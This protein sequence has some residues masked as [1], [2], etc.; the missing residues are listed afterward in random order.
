MAITLLSDSGRQA[1]TIGASGLGVASIPGIVVTAIATSSGR[2]RLISWSVSQDGGSIERLRDSGNQGDL[3]DLVDVCQAAFGFFVTASRLP[4][5]K[6]RVI[7]WKV[8]PQT[9]EIDRAEDDGD[10]E[11]AVGEIAMAD[12]PTSNGSVPFAVTDG[13]GNL[14]LKNWEVDKFGKLHRRGD[15]A[16]QGAA[17]GKASQLALRWGPA[18]L[19]SAMRTA[20]GNLKLIVWS[21]Q[22][23]GSFKRLGQG[24]AGAVSRVSLTAL[25]D[26]RVVTAVRDAGNNLKLISWT[27]SADGM[28]LKRG[29]D[30]G[31]AAGG[32][33][34]IASVF[35]DL[36]GPTPGSPL[37]EGDPILLTAVR[38]KR[39][40]LKLIRWTVPTDTIE[41]LD[42]FA[43]NTGPVD[44]IAQR[45]VS[46]V[47][48]IDIRLV[49][50][51]DG[52]GRLR[53]M[54][55]H[56]D[57]TR[58]PVPLADAFA[59]Y[60]QSFFENTV[61][62]VPPS[63]PGGFGGPACV[64]G[65]I[66]VHLG[67][68]RDT[69]GL[70]FRD[71][72]DSNG[73]FALSASATRVAYPFS[74]EQ[75]AAT[76][77]QIIRLDDGRLLALK[78]GYCWNDV[79]PTPEWFDTVTSPGLDP[80]ARNAL[81]ILRSSDCGHSWD[82]ISVIDSA[83]IAGGKYGWPQL[84][85]DGSWEAVGGFDRTELY[86]DP[87]TKA[88][89]ITG[90]GDAHY[91]LGRKSVINHAEVI[92]RSDDRGE[93][94]QVFEERPEWEKRA[95][96]M[97]STHGWPLL[98]LRMEGGEPHLYGLKKGDSAIGSGRS[99]A[100]AVAG[101]TIKIGYDEGVTDVAS[102]AVSLHSIARIGETDKVRIAYPSVNEDGRQ[103]FEICNVTLVAN[104][105]HISER[106]AR[107]E[108]IDPAKASC[109][110]GAF[111]RDD[112]TGF[113]DSY[114]M[115]AWVEAPPA[116]SPDKDKLLAR[117]KVFFGEFGQY[118]SMALSLDGGT[119]KTFQRIGIGH[120]SGYAGFH[121]NGQPH[122]LAHWREAN[123]IRGNIVSIPK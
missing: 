65:S 46:P 116:I 48:D 97:T 110:L 67:Q 33:D 30:S 16:I 26:D 11:G 95:H 93:S 102:G 120:Y 61:R 112:L 109:T 91:K 103:G 14:V 87:W 85:E 80:N 57:D 1:G 13:A 75:T 62:V 29:P 72:L 98:I 45:I 4:S 113:G 6:L 32:V 15:T 20:G 77:N 111:A 86:Q 49:A 106:I 34:R 81:Y 121:L 51:R 53:L 23:D 70:V 36:S 21:V 47:T 2:L 84:K 52:D 3:A 71:L 5:G 42:E 56:L 59:L 27:V 17:A 37:D 76:D 108:G 94:W 35:H 8:N 44:L 73:S 88:V 66:V 54:S 41:R 104:G 82:L 18:G 68:P 63:L 40:L 12:S 105:E 43:E 122:F 79:S 60:G 9:G 100:A 92:F 107:V 89:W 99:V 58:Q 69:A 19:I 101:E 78:N 38:T 55:Y 96:P 90:H 39:Q 24:G 7:A 118:K 114:S 10:S 50:V 123:A 31:D 117:C 22:S 83:V 28:T 64:R 115:F 74:A 25:R 119:P